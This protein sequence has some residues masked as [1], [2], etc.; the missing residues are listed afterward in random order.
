MLRPFILS[1]VL[2]A[3]ANLAVAPLPAAAQEA[4]IE[5][6]IRDQISA[7]LADDFARAFTHASPTIKSIF[8]TPENFGR[9]VRDG[10]P[11]VHRPAD[12]RMLDQR[13]VAG[14][15]WQ[16]VM[17]TDQAGRLHVLDYQ[18]IQTPDGW[19]INGVQLL[20]SVGVGA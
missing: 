13:E 20:P 3:P 11:M 19:Q 14:R 12:V 4:G 10:Y 2:L 1:L 9:M 15:I 5:S 17:I 16:R 18:M 7:F 6:T 8:R